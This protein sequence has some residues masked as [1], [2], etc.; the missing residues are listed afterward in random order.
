MTDWVVLT[1]RF[2]VLCYFS[3]TVIKHHDQNNL[4]NKMLSCAYSFRRIRAY[5]VWLHSSKEQ[6][7]CL[8]QSLG[9]HTS[10][11]T[12]N[13]LRGTLKMV[14][15]F[16]NW[17]G[18]PQRHTS[19]N[20]VTSSNVSQAVS[21][22]RDQVFKHMSLWEAILFFFFCFF[23]FNIRYFL[24]TLQMLSWKFPVPS[25]CPAPLPT[26][27]H[28]LAYKVRKTKGPQWWLTRPSAATDAAR[29]MSSG[30]TG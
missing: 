3:I 10:K 2:Q 11:P 23:F 22:T 13:R 14:W 5:T 1:L 4:L 29:D 30:G 25:R 6:T 17:K 7:C 20:E 9:T 19:S 28:F 21:Q 26:H 27:S 12:D 24:F 16:W 8:E 18:H 15:V